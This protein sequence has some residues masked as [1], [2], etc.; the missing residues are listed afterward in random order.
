MDVTPDAE[1]VEEEGAVTLVEIDLH[2]AG[3]VVTAEEIW[4]AVTVKVS[5]GGAAIF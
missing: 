5:D 2:F 1:G 4:I 3:V